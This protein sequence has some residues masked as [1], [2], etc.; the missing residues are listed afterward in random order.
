MAKLTLTI[1]RGNAAFSEGNDAYELARIL[2]KLAD[3]L[4]AENTQ[5]AGTVGLHDFNGN[6]V[7]KADWTARPSE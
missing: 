1:E 7:G 5:Y 2:R 3:R 4:E 6:R